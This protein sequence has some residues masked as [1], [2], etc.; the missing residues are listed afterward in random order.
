MNPVTLLIDNPFNLERVV[1]DVDEYGHEKHAVTSIKDSPVTRNDAT[2]IL[3][4]MNGH[5]VGCQ[6]LIQLG[7]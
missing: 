1:I 2:K 4:K 3:K 6:G 7:G 5:S